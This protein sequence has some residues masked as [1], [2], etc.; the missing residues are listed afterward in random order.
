MLIVV[1]YLYAASVVQWALDV[2]IAFR[3]I[4]S[5]F[6]VPDLSIPDRGDLADESVE[7]IFAPQEALFVFNV[8]DNPHMCGLL[9]N[10]IQMIIGDAVVIWRTWAVYQGRMLAILMPCILLLVSFGERHPHFRRY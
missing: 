2:Y 1:V 4:H 7:N 6:M 10:S 9:K 8:R 5:L 3:N